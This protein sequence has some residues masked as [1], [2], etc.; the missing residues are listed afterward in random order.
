[1]RAGLS[2]VFS[3]RRALLWLGVTAVSLTL[4]AAAVGA[5][6][7]APTVTVTQT[8]L[9]LNDGVS[10]GFEPPD[11][12]LGAGPGFVVEVV[13]LAS[14]VWRTGDG[15][16]QPVQTITLASLFSTGADRLTDP[17]ILYDAP[18]SRWFATVSDIDTGSVVLAASRSSDPTVGWN[19]Y[20]FPSGGCPDQP[21]L[22]VADGT[23]VIAADIFSS[24]EQTFSPALGA[25]LWIV[26]KQ[27][28]VAGVAT[29]SSATY[30]PN[31]AYESLAPVQSLSPTSTE[32][33]VAVDIPSARAVHLLTVDGIPPASVSVQE[34]ASPPVSPLQQPPPAEQLASASSFRQPSIDTNDDRVLDSVWENG[35]LWLSANSGCT[36]S[37][38]TKLRSCARVIELATATRSVTWD[39]DVSQSGAYVYFPAIRPDASGNLVIVYGESSSTE[40]PRLV[41]LGR[42]PDGTFSAPVTV[43]QSAGTHQGKRFGDYFGAARDPLDP[44]LVW[45]AG[46]HGVDVANTRGWSTAIAAVEVT[47]AGAQ[48]PAVSA[49]TPPGLKARPVTARAGAAVRLSYV[50]LGGGTAVRRRVVVSAKSTVLFSTATK[51]GSLDVSQSYSVLWRP[52]RRLHGTFRWCVRSILADGTQSPQSCSTVTLR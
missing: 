41:A 12:S 33:V 21:R 8:T 29:V 36:P 14:R 11:V 28:L 1:V 42:A 6:V 20:S 45:V 10:G 5:G 34:V 38:D 18:S 23:V 43:A 25:E 39:T 47:S 50:A 27:Q 32:Y 17:R 35:R 24:C 19:T 22:G 48:P 9:G 26:N 3:S 49:P 13:N 31:R 44:A 30:G 16:P 37:G 15:A 2:A 52:A 51:P 4:T 7:L 46:E 40:L